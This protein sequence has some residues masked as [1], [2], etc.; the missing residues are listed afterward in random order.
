MDDSR[1]CSWLLGGC[2]ALLVLTGCVTTKFDDAIPA[3]VQDQFDHISD[4]GV[5]LRLT[6][7][8]AGEGITI[9]TGA[10]NITLNRL[11]SGMVDELAESKFGGVDAAAPDT[12]A[13]DVTYLNVEERTYQGNPYLYRL[14]MAVRAQLSNADGRAA[15]EFSFNARSDVQGYSMTT[16]QIYNLLLQHIVAIDRFVDGRLASR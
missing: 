11:F 7:R 2:A 1:M 4:G 12:L 10:A 13:I 5:A 3:E 14:D 15:Q 8:P 16:D 6:P 9:N